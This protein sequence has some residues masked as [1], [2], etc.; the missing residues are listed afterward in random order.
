MR[1]KIVSADGHMDLFYL[2][3]DTFTSRTAAHL[4]ER[5][6][7]V[8]SI[9]GKPTWVGDGAV[10][11]AH[12]AWMG[13]A[14][15]STHRGKRMAEAGWEASHPSDP[16]LRLADLDL[17]G[18]EA[19]VI[20]GIRFIED[21]IRDPE[22]VVSTY[23]A[24]NDFIS[25]FCSYNP[26]R[27]LGIAN[28]PAFSAEAASAEIRRIGKH[29]LALRGAM[30]DWFNGPEPIWHPMWE[31]MWTAAEENEVALS[32][33]IGV[34][35]GTTTCGPTSVEQKLK[36]DLPRVSAATHQA[37]VAMQADECLVAI[38]LCG[39]LERH[40][41]LK[42]V[43]AESHIGWIPYILERLDF[44]YKE[45]A[46]KDLIRTPPSEL[47]GRQMWATFQDDRIGAL[48]ANEYGAESF[49]WASDYPHAD[50]VFPDSQSFIQSTMAHLDDTLQRKLTLLNSARLYNLDWL[51]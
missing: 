39:A 42:V 11:G 16:K 24:Y 13:F 33:H 47:F 19:E 22:V 49:C 26:R 9:E 4:K 27:L 44:K 29:G 41:N 7:K 35:H 50:G 46:Y 5:V 20:Y 34:G 15:M 23:R 45:G 14:Q 37:V 25:E 32:F 3:R 36:G 51:L 43:M 8:V 6:P 48:L 30:F 21:S 18:V 10:M 2:P 1:N 17:D 12:A 38:L 40:P 28:V 31:P